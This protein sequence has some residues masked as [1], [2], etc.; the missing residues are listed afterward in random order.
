MVSDEAKICPNCGIQKPVKRSAKWI[1]IAL[2]VVVLFI[3]FSPKND[4]SVKNANPTGSASTQRA[5]PTVER[6]AKQVEAAMQDP[7]KV[8][9]M[10]CMGVNPWKE[11]PAGWTPPT[12]GEC[13]QL[14]Q[15]LGAEADA[16]EKSSSKK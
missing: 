2:G 1:W 3:V 15:V 5:E 13:N 9:L 6:A 16:R 11:K 10:E 4:S 14:K 12:E 7:R 8:R